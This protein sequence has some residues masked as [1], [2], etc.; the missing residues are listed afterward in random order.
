MEIS[1]INGIRVLPSTKVRPVG[2]ELNVSFAIESSAAADEEN[3]SPAK[4]KAAGAEEPEQEE[5]DPN[6]C[7]E[8]SGAEAKA[9]REE[10]LPPTRIDFFA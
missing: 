6:E 9:S 8:S 7:S 3:W 1:P 10:Q 4:G 5:E 2:P